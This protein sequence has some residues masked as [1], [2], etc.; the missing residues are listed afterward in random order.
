MSY[1]QIDIYTITEL[2]EL[3]N[4]IRDKYNDY[5][6]VLRGKL[7]ETFNGF[8]RINNSFSIIAPNLYSLGDLKIIDGNFS[9]SSSAGKPKLNSLGKL[10]RINGEGYLRH[11][12]ISDL[13][14]LN[15]VHGKLNL[16]D[17]PIENLGV[18]KYVGGDLF[19]PKRLEGKI[20]LSG[21]EVKG[22]IKFWKDESYKIIKPIDAVEGLLKSQHEIPY[23]KH[24]YISSFSAIENATAEQKEFYKYFKYEFFN[25]RYINLEGNSNYVFVLFYDFLNQYLRNKN[26]EELFSRYTIL[27]RYYP[28][29]KSYAYRIFIEILKGKKRFEEAWEYEK[30]ICISSIKTVWEYDQ[31]LNRNLFDSSIILRLANYKHLTD[32]GQKNI[33]QIAPFI[34][35]TF[36]KFEEKLESR[37][38][39]NLFFDNNLFYKKV[40]GEYEPKYYLN[41]YSSPAEFEFYNSIDED[42]KKRNYTNPFPHVVEKAII[43]QLKIIIKDAEDLYRIDIGM[44]K[45]GEGWISETELFYKLKNRFKEQQVIHHGNP[46][47]L[48]RQHLD[49]FFPK[50]NIGIEY[51]GLQHY[52]PID[53]FGGE[54]AFLKNQE[55]DLRKIELCR[56]NNCHLIHVKKDYD[57]ESLCNEI[58]LEILKRTK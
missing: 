15:Y 27:A 2:D 55:R 23:W 28:L 35:Q 18:L 49:I 53:F 11:S 45:I 51:Q 56:N 30:K 8:E 7:I 52:E 54:K 21:I 43:N 34:E 58:E 13:G 33:K 25:S 57:F 32:F 29:T 42:A 40:N 16:R 17:T 22:K 41:F 6:I 24:S 39:L 1:N 44:P 38:F 19:L 48:G 46:K 37:R 36:A 14:N 9:I 5:N 50:L 20:D 10:E 47:W 12:N 31:L 26:F 3:R 4:N